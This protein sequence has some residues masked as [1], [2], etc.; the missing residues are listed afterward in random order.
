[1]SRA[2]RTPAELAAAG[3]IQ[4]ERI[5]EL[6]PVAARYAVAVTPAIAALIDPA[7]PADPHRPSVPAPDGRTRHPA[8]RP[9]RPGRRRSP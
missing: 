6:D 2:L 3:L 7:D 1:M 8:R 9:R 5:A 4:A